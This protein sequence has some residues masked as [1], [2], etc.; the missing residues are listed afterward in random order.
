MGL[1]MNKLC[2][3]MAAWLNTSQIGQFD[4]KIKI[5]QS[6]SLET[7]LL[8]CRSPLCDGS[9]LLRTHTQVTFMI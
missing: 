9:E 3:K 4:V 2:M 5:C 6:P 8:I 1:R 7:I